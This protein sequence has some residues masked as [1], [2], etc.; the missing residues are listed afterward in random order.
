LL[1]LVHTQITDAGLEEFRSALPK[2]KIFR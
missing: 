2:C 1:D